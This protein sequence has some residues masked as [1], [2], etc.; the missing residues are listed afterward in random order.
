ML[1]KYYDPS[2]HYA[3]ANR[4]QTEPTIIIYKLLCPVGP[5]QLDWYRHA[6]DVTVTAHAAA[7]PVL[8]IVMHRPCAAAA[9]QTASWYRQQKS[10]PIWTHFF[11]CHYV[12]NDDPYRHKTQHMSCIWSVNVC[13]QNFAVVQRCVSEE[14]GHRQNKQTLKCLVDI[15]WKC[16]LFDYRLGLVRWYRWLT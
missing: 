16:F 7:R 9:S 11:K 14:I 6:C 5:L 2:L 10:R 15:R 13:M 1:E 8:L 3:V 12:R 4:R